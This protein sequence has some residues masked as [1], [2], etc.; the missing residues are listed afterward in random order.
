MNTN[1]MVMID[2]VCTGPVFDVKQTSRRGGNVWDD[3]D[4]WI[5][6]TTYKIMYRLNE[7]TGTVRH[8]PAKISLDS[9]SPRLSLR[10]SLHASLGAVSFPISSWNATRS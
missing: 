1:T 8:S 4:V 7:F 6:V 3:D 5:Y 2:S 9:G 10:A